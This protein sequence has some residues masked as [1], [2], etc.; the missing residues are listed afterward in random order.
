M[1][2]GRIGTLHYGAGEDYEHFI[3]GVGEDRNAA[4][5]SRGG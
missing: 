5:W 3:P 1:E 4:F 2:P